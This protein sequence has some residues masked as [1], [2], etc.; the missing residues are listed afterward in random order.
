MNDQERVYRNKEQE[1][2]QHKELGRWSQIGK[3]TEPRMEIR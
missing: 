2:W 1:L 3:Y